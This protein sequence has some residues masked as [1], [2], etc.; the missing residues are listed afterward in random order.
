MTPESVY[1]EF[2]KLFPD[3]SY[4]SIQYT[5][6]STERNTIRITMQDFSTY[7]FTYP[8]NGHFT[9]YAEKLKG[10]VK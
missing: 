2:K 1:N 9:L 7:L 6:V 10:G 5:H 3:L 4:K 8:A